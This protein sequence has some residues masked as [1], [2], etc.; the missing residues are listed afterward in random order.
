M[1]AQKISLKVTSEDL[2][3]IAQAA[4]E[5]GVHLATAYRWVEKKRLHAFRIGEQ[6]FVTIDEVKALKEAK[7]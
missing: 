5:L 7:P 4:E 6:L 3:T 2:L 1:C